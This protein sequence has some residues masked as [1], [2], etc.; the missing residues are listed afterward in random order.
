LQTLPQRLKPFLYLACYARLKA[1]STRPPA[2]SNRES[3]LAT[4]NTGFQ[5]GFS[6]NTTAFCC[7][8]S[9]SVSRLTLNFLRSTGKPVGKFVCKHF[10]SP[11]E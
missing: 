9:G 4:E 8:D 6:T 11:E 3:A 2:Y 1:C 7:S 10:A 5:I